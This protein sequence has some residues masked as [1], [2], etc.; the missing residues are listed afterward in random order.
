MY[1]SGKELIS[2]IMQHAELARED[3]KSSSLLLFWKQMQINKQVLK[4]LAT[5]LCNR[6]RTEAKAQTATSS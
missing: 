2:W 5:G 4:K 1:D 3:L 6:I